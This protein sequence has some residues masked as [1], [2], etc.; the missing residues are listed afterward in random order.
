MAAAAAAAVFV[1]VQVG[2]SFSHQTR[3]R[4]HRA[5]WTTPLKCPSLWNIA[6]LSKATVQALLSVS[7]LSLKFFEF[8]ILLV[9]AAFYFLQYLVLIL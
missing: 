8:L 1:A 9:K 2:R 3:R 4:F 6:A 5:R 7:D